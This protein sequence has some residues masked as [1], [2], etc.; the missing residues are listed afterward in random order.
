[1]LADGC[2]DGSPWPS[3]PGVDDDHVDCVLGEITVGLGDGNGSIQHIKRLHHIG[4]VHRGHRGINA[5]DHPL[6]CTNIVLGEA[7]IGGERHN[8]LCRHNLSP[9]VDFARRT[10]LKIRS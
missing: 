1:M 2:Q 9:R 5:I 4:D 10:R 8:P 6:H 3:H 7:K